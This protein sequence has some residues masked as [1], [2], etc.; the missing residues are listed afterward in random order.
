M[1]FL[2]SSSSLLKQLQAVS[3]VLTTSSTLPILGNFLF[4]INDQQLKVSAS[5]LETTMS[6]ELQLEKSDDNGSVAVPA[7][8]LLDTLKTFAE[9]PLNFSIDESKFTIEISSENGKYKL[10]GLNGDDFPKIPS[11]DSSTS[12][13][14][15]ADVLFN[16]IDKTIFATSNETHRPIMCGINISIEEDKTTFVATD[17]HKL[18]KCIRSDASS[19]QPS[20]I[21]LPKKPMNLLK[22][23]LPDANSDVTI[24]YNDTN[25]SF[26]FDGIHQ[27][28]KKHL[29]H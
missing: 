28:R 21:T 2:V 9:Q 7:R 6:S 3:G 16:A 23:L 26:E 27:T 24:Q 22:N 20:S 11:I 8:L 13:K 19:D 5:D 25:A 10:V 12:V 1:K 4:E 14:L 17:A 29:Y 15:N 18:V